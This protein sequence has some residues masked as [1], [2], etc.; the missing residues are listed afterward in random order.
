V[1]PAWRAKD[2]I[3]EPPSQPNALSAVTTPSNA[4]GQGNS[5][6]VRLAG[7]LRVS[8]ARSMYFEKIRVTGT[9]VT[10]HV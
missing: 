4:G 5:N 10:V 7:R 9:G 8:A 1:M 2:T 6:G 3:A